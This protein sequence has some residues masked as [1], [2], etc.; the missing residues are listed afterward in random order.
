MQ[1]RVILN[2]HRAHVD[3]AQHTGRGHRL[4]QGPGTFRVDESQISAAP[5]VARDG[6]QVDDPVDAGECRGQAVG[7]GDVAAAQLKV[8]ALYRGQSP[9]HG[10][11]GGGGADEGH[12]VVAGV[13]QGGHDVLTDEAAGAG[14][15]DGRHG[16]G[17]LLA[18]GRLVATVA[19]PFGR[20]PSCGCAGMAPSQN[21]SIGG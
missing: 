1:V 12:D 21:R 3:Q 19:I 4:D 15:E 18:R 2:A 6:H 9:G 14:D 16:D 17:S 8:R 5:E 11:S 10:L 13:K 20:D 7:A